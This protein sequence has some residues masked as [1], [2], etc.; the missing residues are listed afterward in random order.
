MFHGNQLKDGE[1]RVSVHT[2]HGGG[3]EG[4]VFSVFY[5]E[6]PSYLEAGFWQM[7][8]LLTCVVSCIL[9]TISLYRR[10]SFSVFKEC[11]VLDPSPNMCIM[12]PNVPLGSIHRQE[13]GAS[14]AVS[15]TFKPIT[16]THT[17]PCKLER[18]ANTNTS[19]NIVYANAKVKSNK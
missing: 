18:F 4:N 5:I 17:P 3:C 12:S 8:S 11:I 1:E 19:Q 14:A 10:G 7:Y 13:K 9:S 16:T 6:L 15:K 2:G